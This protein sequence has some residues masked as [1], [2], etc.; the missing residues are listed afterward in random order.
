M[1]KD[2]RKLLARTLATLTLL[3][4]SL[5]LAPTP[6][7]AQ[8]TESDPVIVAGAEV[9]RYYRQ[10]G[11]YEVREPFLTALNELGGVT[12][13]GYPVS[14]PFQGVD[15]CIYQDFQVVLLQQCAGGAVVRANTFQILEENGADERLSQLGIQKGEADPGTTFEQAKAN[16]LAWLEDAAIRD[17][18]LTQCGNGN[19]DAAVEFC[20]LPMNHPTSAGPFVS[21]RFQR[22]AF[23]RWTVEGP[24]GIRAGDVTPALGGDLLKD[25]GVL[26][27][28]V[29]QP[30]ALGQPPA[31]TQVAFARVGGSAP[32]GQTGTTFRDKATLGIVQNPVEAAPAA[33]PTAFGAGREGQ[34]LSVGDV[35]RAPGTGSGLV[36]FLQGTTTEVTPGTT[37][38]VREIAPAPSGGGILLTVQQT[39]G[40]AIH[41]ITNLIA[42]SQFKV[43]TPNATAVVRGTILR[44]TVQSDGSTRIEVWDAPAEV[45][46]GNQTI[47][48]PADQ[49]V[50]VQANG[51]VGPPQPNTAQRPPSNPPPTGGTSTGATATPSV[52][53]T[54]TPQPVAQRTQPLNYGFQGDFFRTSL[55]PDSIKKVQ[56]AGFGWAKQ[57]VLWDQYEIDQA[58]CT[59]LRPYNATTNSSGCLELLPGRY[60]KGDQI[61]FL[62]AVINDLSGAGLN[63]MISVVRAPSFLAASGGHAPA[64]PNRLG[65][66]LTALVNR[67]KGKIKAIEPWNEQNLSWEWGS[68]RLWPNAPSAPPQGAVDFVN[69]QKAAYRAIKAADGNVTVV[70]PAMTPTGLGE[71]W[72]NPE[73]R[74]QGFCLE[75]VRTAIDDRL[76]LD[77]VFQV[78]GGE[79]KGFFDVLGV[80]PSGYNNAPDD[81]TDVQSPQSDGGFK[82]HGSFYIKRYQQLRKVQEKYGDNHPMW[83]TEVG[84]SVTRVTVPGYEYGAN[85]TEEER[86][87]YF[88][89]ML[90]QI[91][92]EAPDVSNLFIWNLNFRQLVGE[93][94]EKYGFGVLNSDGSGTPAYNCVQDFVRNNNRTTRPDCTPYPVQQQG[95]R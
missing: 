27:G 25:T 69:L 13:A 85:N 33:A 38:V 19:A 53:P 65:D 11:G 6:V 45:T 91:N 3:G 71:C 72:E 16:R 42:G 24:G 4:Q 90:A 18:Y 67:Y 7:S 84:W 68:G 95:I 39:A 56:D 12:R 88:A 94:D 40:Q 55:R 9:G 35:V 50:V 89:G 49:V 46:I 21:Q 36:T 30:H 87:R 20:G 37:I 14:A 83:F 79:V 26:A 51:T 60:F 54:A 28:P 44:I 52:T 74:T 62:D 48:V 93:P 77:F 15:G 32:T 92:R 64:D 82:G 23:Q 43:V 57:Q 29:T 80:H 61:S 66:F 1:R 8:S 41:R 59:S 17:R 22:I 86:G 5:A 81:W 76:Y 63:I 70:L 31:L 75:A 2:P 10:T 47:I 34:E 78:N 58:T 73:A